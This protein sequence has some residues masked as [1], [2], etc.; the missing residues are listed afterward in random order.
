MKSINNCNN[1][2]NSLVCAGIPTMLY[3]FCFNL[4]MQKYFPTFA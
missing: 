2:K 1:E 3:T 4:D